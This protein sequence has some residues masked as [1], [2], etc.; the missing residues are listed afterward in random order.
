M[1]QYS[2]AIDAITPIRAAG[3]SR[4]VGIGV[5][6]A[7]HVVIG[8]A[9]ITGLAQKVVDSIRAPLEARLIEEV[10]KPDLPP[11]PPPPAQIKPRLK[12]TAAPPPPPFVPPPEVTVAAPPPAPTIAAFT[13]IAPPAPVEIRPEPPAPAPAPPPKVEQESIDVACQHMVRPLLPRRAQLEG[14]GGSVRA[15]ATIR[16]GKVVDVQILSAKP[17]GVFESAV[18]TAML[19]YGC[20]TNGTSEITAVQNF[21]FKAAD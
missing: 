11:P 12:L 2:P 16:D 21:E 5:V 6:V 7:V 13:P 4:A 18:R 3:D 9:L 10:K 14:I 1:T 20:Q 15:Q 17:L 8:Y 19:Q